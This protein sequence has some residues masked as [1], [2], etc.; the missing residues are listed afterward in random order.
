MRLFSVSDGEED[1]QI[2]K[3]HLSVVEEVKE[4][5]ARSW[6]LQVNLQTATKCLQ[7]EMII[8]R[9]RYPPLLAVL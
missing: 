8:Q 1:P 4:P 3:M 2:T 6:L 9:P 5:I 7:E